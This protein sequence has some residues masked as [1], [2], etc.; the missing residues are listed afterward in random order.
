MRIIVRFLA[1]LVPAL[2]LAIIGSLR[3]MDSL[4][5]R[6]LVA[7]LKRRS[8]LIV[9]GIH[10]ALVED[11]LSG[12]T[13]A[14]RALLN[15][16]SGDDRLSGAVACSGDRSLIARSD[17]V[18]AD[19]SC[20]RAWRDT[21][22]R[23]SRII[24]TGG[25]RLHETMVPVLNDGKLLAYVIILHDTSSMD[26]RHATTRK[27]IVLMVLG[28]S[29]LF[30]LLTVGIYR[31]SMGESLRRVRALLR[32]LLRGDLAGLDGLL[33]KGELSPL[34]RPLLKIVRELRRSQDMARSQDAA[35]G[36]NPARLRTEVRKLFGDSQ[37]CVIAN[38]E[39]YVH[40][41]RSDGGIETLLPASGLVT[42]VEPLVRACSGL[43]IAHG[44]GTADRQTADAEGRLLVPPG[45]PEY[46]LKRVWLTRAEEEGYYSG[47][48]NEG[49]W[50]LCHIAHA[51]PRFNSDDYSHYVQVN[52][53]F[54][55]AFLQEPTERGTVVLIQDYHFALLPLMIR[56]ERP[57]AILSLFW[58]IPWPNPEAFGICP[59]KKQ[60]LTGMLGAD[61]IGFHTQFHCNNFLDTVDRNLEAR[62][63]RENFS[64][65]F[66]GHVCY[67]KPFSIS[68]EWPPNYDIPI[69]E[70]GREKEALF[71]ELGLPMDIRVGLGVDR[72]DYTKG[73][74]ERLESVERLLDRH[75]EL[76][77][78]LVFIQIGAPSRTTIRRYQDLNAELVEMAEKIN[79]KFE[80]RGGPPPV[81][82]RLTHH[83]PPD[84]Y[85]Y[86]RAADFCFV[87]SLHDGMNLVAKEYVAARKDLG[88]AL[89]LSTFA[90]A[91]RELLDAL[92][93]NPYDI[94]ECANALHHAL[95]MSDGERRQRMERLRA[96]VTEKNVYAW[97]GSLL[98]EIHR[99]ARRK[100][101]LATP[102]SP[103][104]S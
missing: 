49:L 5:R 30:L 7:D 96:V 54:A 24:V 52:E 14:I 20:S 84:I 71:S 15:R 68:V 48:S 60:L 81:L 28:I 101:A 64:V 59:W 65:S 89:V 88:G 3:L 1:L 4:E 103:D 56:N 51:R 42:A 80:G 74:V 73:L 23:A 36:W 2:A 55:K 33:A 9:D 10:D 90:G 83:N 61:L 25:G 69:E 76:V 16:I 58:H 46:Q 104:P 6:W 37:L 34:G 67:V 11:L 22:A 12:K 100:I 72:V 29:L 92:L 19:V 82:L 32:G 85:R 57:D 43:W 18:P 21:G 97:A 44:S 102:R 45:R 99:I 35:P 39:P 94:D 38:R 87:S 86:Y 63:D 62:V 27:Y 47:F 41:H 77:G 53:K 50:P 66:R 93:V 91:S 70:F 95:V 17:S 78:R 8:L 79:R 26:E 75:P 40:N 13:P 98:G 31:W